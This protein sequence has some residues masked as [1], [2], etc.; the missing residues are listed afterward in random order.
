MKSFSVFL[1][2]GKI[3]NQLTLKQSLC[4]ID[5]VNKIIMISKHKNYK[6]KY[7]KHC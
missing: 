2:Y 3:H 6:N 1:I 5:I 4:Y 7:A